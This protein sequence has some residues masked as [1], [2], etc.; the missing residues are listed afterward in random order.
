VASALS[1]ALDTA[2]VVIHRMTEAWA[3][4]LL[5]RF[6]GSMGIHRDSSDIAHH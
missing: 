2:V 3:P 1:F 5:V 6:P 4:V